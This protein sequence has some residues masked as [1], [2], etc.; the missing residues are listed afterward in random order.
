M[1]WLIFFS[2][3]LRPTSE[4]QIPT[5]DNEHSARLDVGFRIIA[6]SLW[7]KGIAGPVYNHYSGFSVSLGH[8][9]QVFPSFPAV[10][11]T[12]H[13]QD[14]ENYPRYHRNICEI[15]KRIGISPKDCLG[16]EIEL[17]RN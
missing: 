11:S 10:I 15:F 5:R 7:I 17:L 6:Q 4:R 16:L 2:L 3:R 14:V 8:F 13:R 12:V 9:I 1:L